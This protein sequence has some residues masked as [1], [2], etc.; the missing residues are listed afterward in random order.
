M[1][2]E[3]GF[4][5][6]I[7]YVCEIVSTVR[8]SPLPGMPPHVCGVYDLRGQLLPAFDLSALLD[9]TPRNGLVNDWAIV[10]GQAHPEFL[11]LSDAA[12]EILTLPL[13]D[14]HP[15]EP[16]AGDKA[17]QCATTGAGTVILDGRRLLEDRQL[18]LEDNQ[19]TADEAERT[20]TDASP[21]RE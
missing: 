13:E 18:F 19:I 7:G 10:C 17:W 14:I 1:L 12:P 4:A 2:S 5:L 15:A 3:R 21:V 8:V 9:G 20:G 6:E 16:G 11:I